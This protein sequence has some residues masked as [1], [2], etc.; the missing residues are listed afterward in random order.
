MDSAA[1]NGAGDL[2][3]PGGGADAAVVVDRLV[4]R[5]RR[6]TALDGVSLRVRRGE[7]YGLIGADGAGKSSLLK[8]V[9]GVLSFEAG[10]LRVLGQ[11]LASE[12]DAAR[13]AQ[14]IGFMPQGLGLNLFPELSVDEN[15]DFFADLRGV[16]QA[17][18][19]TRKQQLLAMTRLQPFRARPMKQL[20]GGM[21]QKLGLVCTLI[22]AP[23]LVLLDEPTTGVDALARRDFWQLL[24]ALMRQGG[25]SA[26]VSTAYLDEAGRF[27]RVG[28]M[29]AGALFAEGPP[30]SL[31]QQLP[32]LEDFFVARVSELTHQPI[33]PAPRADALAP[34]AAVRPGGPAAIE[35]R[36][37]TRD[38][39][40]FRAAD[41]VSFR[42]ARGEIFG[43]LGANGAGKTTVI[44]MLTGI[45]PPTSGVGQVA[46]A[47]MRHA[48][49]QIRQ[50]IG[51]MSQAFSLYADLSV[52][53]N[54]MLY[55]GLYGLRGRAARERA[56]A[57][58][59]LGGL[60]GHLDEPVGGLPVGLRQRLALG[61]ALL[62]RPQVLFLDEPTSG[63]DPLGRRRFWSILWQ[64]ARE[65]QV[66]VLLSTHHLT[67]AELCDHLVLLY[68]GRVVADATPAQ[69]KQ[70]LQRQLGLA[71][72]PSLEDVFVH[73]VGTR[74][75]GAA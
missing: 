15:I 44:K 60:G 61:C 6:R 26:L 66:A 11:P 9:A 50:R 17:L 63:V 46:G 52:R 67:E 53:E 58:T 3:G 69:M 55:A 24:P 62:H 54:L 35:A 74:Q 30:G 40:G 34:G 13:V 47:D 48:S 7:V 39:G 68:D 45:L 10:S 37:L 51:Y 56:A 49:R 5:Y 57:V 1:M 22:H 42:V 32:T 27:D 29:H 72:E 12:R 20:S 75:G 71:H 4:K 64:L 65:E 43:L 8:A 19:D 41:G 73:E 36:S 28:L 23:E 33:V 2:P 70:R 16:P 21:K 59:G 14:R 25:M 18:R 31:R 38:F